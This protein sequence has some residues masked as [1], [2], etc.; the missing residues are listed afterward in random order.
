MGTTCLVLKCVVKEQQ[1]M[2][3]KKKKK[4]KIEEDEKWTCF[5][6]SVSFFLLFSFSQNLSFESVFGNNKCL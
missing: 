2:N 3:N 5:A 1:K 4:K 6:S